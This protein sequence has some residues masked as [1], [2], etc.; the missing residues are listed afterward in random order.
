LTDI[1]DPL[2]ASL[3]IEAEAPG[4]AHAVGEDFVEAVGSTEKGIAGGGRVRNTGGVDVD[5]EDL[6]Q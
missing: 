6:P 1:P 4:V 5:A 3:R 2:V